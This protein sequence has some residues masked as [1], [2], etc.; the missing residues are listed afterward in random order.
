MPVGKAL[1]FVITFEYKTVMS[2]SAAKHAHY[3][4]DALVTKRVR[5]K[6]VTAL[7]PVNFQLS[8]RS[9]TNSVSLTV[10]CVPTFNNGG[11]VTLFASA[12]NG[13]GISSAAG[14]LLDGSNLGTPGNNGVFMISP[15]GRSIS[16]EPRGQT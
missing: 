5:G 8:Y 9:S 14:V 2:A 6:T 4:V 16:R 15:R 11:Q 1:G 3:Q 10:P 12:A 7:H 13:T